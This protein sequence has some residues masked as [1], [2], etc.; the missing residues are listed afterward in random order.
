MVTHPTGDLRRGKAWL[1]LLIRGMQGKRE[2]DRWQFIRQPP[3]VLRDTNGGHG[4]MA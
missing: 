2:T 3:H 1:N 4:Q